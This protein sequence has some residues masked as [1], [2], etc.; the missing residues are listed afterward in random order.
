MSSPQS[1]QKKSADNQI[2]HKSRRRPPGHRWLNVLL[3]E[4]TFNHLHI[5]ARLSNMSFK[6]YMEQ[7]SAAAFPL[8]GAVVSEDGIPEIK[9]DT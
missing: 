4:K 1:S 8:T 9:A 2:E 3:P 6:D 5:Q 7:F